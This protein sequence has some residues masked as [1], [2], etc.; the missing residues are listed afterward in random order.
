MTEEYYGLIVEIE[1]VADKRDEL[2]TILDKAFVDIPGILNHIIS[3]SK[4]K[5]DTIWVT[6]V[7]E[8]KEA[9][10]ASFEIPSVK[11]AMAVGRT[12]ITNIGQRIETYP[13]AGLNR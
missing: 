3:I 8:N 7:W 4:D 2:V 9:H 5:P 12:M 11:S 13:V 1:V 10:T 6:E